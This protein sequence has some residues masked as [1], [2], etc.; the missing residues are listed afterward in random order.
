MSV[1]AYNFGS[2]E[3]CCTTLS[4]HKQFVAELDKRIASICESDALL[5]DL[6][7]MV[8]SLPGNIVYSKLVSD[9]VNSLAHHQTGQAY[10][11]TL[12][13]MNSENFEIYIDRNSTLVQ[14]RKSIERSLS[15]RVKVQG[16]RRK[17]NWKSFWKKHDILVNSTGKKLR[18]PHSN[19]KHSRLDD[20][21]VISN[22]CCKIESVGITNGAT[23]TLLNRRH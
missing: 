5:N 6:A 10:C 12:E 17:L 18:L 22:L 3:P 20:D 11:L 7:P 8:K 13:K 14:F 23:V 1:K 16:F 21:E 4:Q 9:H 19:G 15:I 2:T